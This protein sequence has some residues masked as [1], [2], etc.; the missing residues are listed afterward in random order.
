MND[1]M[2]TPKADDRAGP[3]ARPAPTAEERLGRIR[4]L[5]ARALTRPD[6]LA[7]NL[8]VLAGDLMLFAYRMSQSLEESLAGAPGPAGPPPGFVQ[9][10]ETYL[11]FVRQLDRL[12]AISRAASRP[13]VPPPAATPPAGE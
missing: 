1:T 2:A 8:E 6:P 5:Q 13:A 10:A 7:A 12:V 9:Q 11:K 4:E 3:R